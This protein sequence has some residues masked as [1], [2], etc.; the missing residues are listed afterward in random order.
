MRLMQLTLDCL[1]VNLCICDYVETGPIGL[2]GLIFVF[3]CVI[4]CCLSHYHHHH[5]PINAP[6]AGAQPFL[7]NYI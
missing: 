5:K 3:C 1:Y 4:L 6:I 7:M 2:H